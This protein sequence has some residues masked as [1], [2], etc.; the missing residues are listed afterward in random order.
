MRNTHTHVADA[1]YV[2]DVR[3]V[4][5]VLARPIVRTFLP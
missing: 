1:P 3:N 5:D 4:A 2:R